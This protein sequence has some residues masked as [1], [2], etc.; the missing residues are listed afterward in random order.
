MMM[1]KSVLF[2]S[3]RSPFNQIL[4]R[5]TT[6]HSSND[7]LRMSY[8]GFSTMERR[9]TALVLGSSGALGSAVSRH[10]SQTLKMKVIGADIVEL[11]TELTHSWD[12]DGFISLPDN[13][14]L[15]QLTTQL[16][17]G[18]ID[19]LYYEDQ[20]EEEENDRGLDL[21]VVASGGWEGDPIRE[22]SKNKDQ[23]DQLIKFAQ[24]YTE[25]ILRM[26]KMNLDP[27]IAAG[28][29]AQ[30]MSS[31]SSSDGL[32]VVLGAT[33]S[34][35]PTPGMMG[36]GLAKVATHHLVQTLGTMTGNPLEPKIIRKQAAGLH[37]FD[38]TVIGLLPTTI[39]TPNNRKAMPQ[40]K[41][42][43]WTKPLDIAIQ[44]GKWAEN[45]LSRPHSGSLVKV[46]AG[47]EGATFELVY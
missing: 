45:P 1:N 23:P 11:P 10:L 13:A 30:F 47:A 27:V 35:L 44:I 37:Q 42:D 17:Q 16:V 28:F 40:G 7:M 2:Q 41:F 19:Y 5:G 46:F 31:S 15:P 12:L 33:A 6:I 20:E 43:Q 3:F 21:I 14:P 26:R 38:M 34:L 36:Y 32:M 8:K 25:S 4:R 22:F 29:V 39:D 24:N 18:V 9:K